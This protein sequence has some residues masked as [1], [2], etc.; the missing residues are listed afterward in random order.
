[1]RQISRQIIISWKIGYK[2]IIISLNDNDMDNQPAIIRFLSTL[3]SITKSP[4]E[5]KRILQ[6][7]FNIPMT[8]DI[9]EEVNNMCNLSQGV[10]DYGVAQG[11]HETKVNVAIKMLKKKF[12]LSVVEEISNL[13]MET[14]QSIAKENNL[15]VIEK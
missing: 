9:E 6:D 1:M 5:K 4:T 2:T 11:I 13:P 3:F 15:T 10:Y 7:D 8:K 14:I 12:P